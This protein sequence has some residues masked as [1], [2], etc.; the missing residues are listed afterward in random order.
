MGILL[1]VAWT[2]D[3]LRGLRRERWPP[4]FTTLAGRRNHRAHHLAAGNACAILLDE[5]SDYGIWTRRRQGEGW[6]VC[7]IW[8]RFY[9]ELNDLLPQDRRH[10]TFAHTLERR[11]AVKDLIEAL[12]V[13]HTEVDLILVNGES[14]GFGHL[15]RPDDR[16]SVYPVFESLD[17]TPLVRVRPEPLRVTRFVVDGHLGRLAAYLRL[18]GFDTLYKNDYRDE[19]LSRISRDERRILLTRDRGLLK[20]AMVTHGYCVRSQ[21]PREQ[22][23]EVLRRFHL[24]RSVSLGRRCVRC[25]GL[26]APV[27]KVEIIDQLEPLTRRYY[28]DFCRCDTCGHVYWPGSHYARLQQFVEETLARC[29]TNEA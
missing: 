23:V 11:A 15:V 26:L 10:R 29:E 1:S 9:A 3:G 28:T 17:I 13:P 25:N 24:A 18:L 27:E 22:I 6:P 2:P 5:Q 16:I 20:R 21:K 14:V 7:V 19:E 12:G 4:V 8:L